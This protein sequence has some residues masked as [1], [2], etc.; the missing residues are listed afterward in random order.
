MSAYTLESYLNAFEEE[1]LQLFKAKFMEMMKDFD[2]A[3]VYQD[4]S[5]YIEE[6]NQ[7]ETNY[8]VIED[9]HGLGIRIGELD[10][11]YGNLEVFPME[12][13]HPRS[14]CETDREGLKTFLIR[15]NFRLTSVIVTFHPEDNYLT[16]E[17]WIVAENETFLRWDGELFEAKSTEYA[18]LMWLFVAIGDYFYEYFE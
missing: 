3:H 2:I 14:S 4:L 17:H 15:D 1:A 13:V 7:E 10:E 12:G 9:G 18:Y 6:G 8:R 5:R 16:V 11:S